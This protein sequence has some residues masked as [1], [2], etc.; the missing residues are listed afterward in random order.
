MPYLGT[1]LCKVQF[2]IVKDILSLVKVMNE[3]LL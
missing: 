2:K 1:R 3:V